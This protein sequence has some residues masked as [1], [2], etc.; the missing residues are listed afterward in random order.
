MAN[1]LELDPEEIRRIGL[2]AMEAAA[3]YYESLPAR[4]IMPETT[5]S[6]LRA[7]LDEP[8]P[9]QGTD[10]S[11]LLATFERTLL[12]NS[13]HNAHPRFFGYVAS[14]GAP[15]AAMGD[16]LVSALN[17][18]VTSWRSAPAPTELEHITIRWL[19]EIL[20]YPSSAAGLFVSGGS[21]ANFAGLAAA[22]SARAGCDVT[23]SG[24]AQVGKAMRVYVSS[25]GHSSIA[26][27]AGLLG[28]GTENVR[29]VNIDERYRLDVAD[30]ER[31][32]GEDRAAGHLPICVIA[33]AGAV[34]TGAF[35]PI[36]EIAAVARKHDL[37]LHVDGAYGGFSALAPSARPHFREIHLADSV[38]LDP[39]KWLYG[40]MGC[41]AILYKD[42][43]AARAAFAHQAEYTRVLGLEHDEAFAF[44]DYGPE[45]SRPFRAFTVWL[46]LKYAGID[47]LA[48]AVESNLA[49]ARHAG[50]VIRESPDLEL[51]APVELSIFC[52]RYRPA[53]FSGNLDAL[54]ERLL[55]ELQRMGS[56]YLSNARLRG[57]FALRGCVLNYRTT[58]A[59]I[60]RMFEDV[61]A[62]AARIQ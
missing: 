21:M 33:N 48:G 26:K 5:S 50:Q 7:L 32:I 3:R 58:P 4:R 19:A 16:V 22:R 47:C 52:F 60:D 30:L 56:S 12:P 13:R 41:G 45:L 43:G 40:N 59:D 2:A 18:N 1:R 24:V 28:I 34:A 11:G 53:G 49:C 44:W 31:S 25:E 55:I 42:A 23:R 6:A 62:A 10:F 36:G 54:N 38:A 15:V 29:L 57:R 14:P 37:W 20:G 61:R 39:H 9:R 46:V 17:S 35:D 51:L 8:L 27:A